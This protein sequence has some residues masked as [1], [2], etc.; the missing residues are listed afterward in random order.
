M[1]LRK[2]SSPV[3]KSDEQIQWLW[4][5]NAGNGL[6]VSSMLIKQDCNLFNVQLF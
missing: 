6:L 3:H 2:I 4:L 1:P 5:I